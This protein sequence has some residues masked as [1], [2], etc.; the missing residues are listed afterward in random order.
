[1]RLRRVIQRGRLPLGLVASALVAAACG[2]GG[3]SADGTA[4]ARTGRRSDAIQGG[5]TDTTSTFAVGVV[6]DQNGMCSGT[7]IAPNL[8]L[9]ARHCVADD[10]G[11]DFVNCKTNRFFP[12][13]P[14]S[15]FKIDTRANADFATAQ[16]E[17]VKVVVPADDLFCG[18]DLALLVTKTLVPS[19]VAIP[20]TP[21]IDPPLTDRAKYGTTLTAIG[22]GTQSP[23]ASDDG[24]RRRRDGVT[25]DCVPG[26]ATG[27]SPATFDMT[28][29]ELAAGSG[30]CEGDSGSGAYDTKSIAAGAPIV[31]GV[32][33]RAADNGT[34]CVD[35]V[36]ERTDS[37]ASFLVAVA[38][39]AAATGGYAVPAWANGVGPTP[40]VDGG[41]TSGDPGA[42]NEA[43][44]ASSDPSDPASSGGTTTTTTSGCGIGGARAA[45]HGASG[46]TWTVA[47]IVTILLP[48]ARRRRSRSPAESRDLG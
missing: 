4:G 39:D 23:G 44:G 17:V 10:N 1:M 33:S 9:T 37:A 20:A 5:K 31:M 32:L 8:V 24:T 14:P 29:A 7:L 28:T 25:I 35:A 13:R 6:D 18:N 27:C 48:L 46:L 21:A 11:G 41:T 19:S 40:P 47:A 16:L 12:A 34:S 42:A 36:Y 3:T 38:K 43:G 45:A 15:S 22:Y 26:D 2:S 30:L